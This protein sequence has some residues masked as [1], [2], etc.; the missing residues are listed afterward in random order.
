MAG[1]PD[2]PCGGWDSIEAPDLTPPD[3][4][5]TSSPPPDPDIRAA[6]VAP[7]VA[8]AGFA[9]CGVPPDLNALRKLPAAAF[10]PPIIALPASVDVYKRQAPSNIPS[11]FQEKEP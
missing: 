8:A 9:P 1:E 11:I 6:A 2:A 7:V 5:E 10:P 4:G 3:G